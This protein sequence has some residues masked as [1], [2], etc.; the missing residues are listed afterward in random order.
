MVL[1]NLPGLYMSLLGIVFFE[2]T[3]NINVRCKINEL[4]NRNWTFEQLR[5]VSQ[6]GLNKKTVRRISN[7]G[8]CSK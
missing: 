6:A 5:C 1:I 8:I 3:Q 7:Q 4:E 2:D